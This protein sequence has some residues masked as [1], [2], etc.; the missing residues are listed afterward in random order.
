MVKAVGCQD[1]KLW[2]VDNGIFKQANGVIIQASVEGEL[3]GSGTLET[4]QVPVGGTPDPQRVL[5]DYLRVLPI[6]QDGKCKPS[7]QFLQIPGT[8]ALT[9]SC[10]RF[11]WSVQVSVLSSSA[12]VTELSIFTDFPRKFH[13]NK[14]SVS[15][16]SL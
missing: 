12:P 10:L 6:P 9:A 14:H 4:C 5:Y 3:K 2:A 16:E 8:H 15:L 7:T 13:H 1:K 11:L